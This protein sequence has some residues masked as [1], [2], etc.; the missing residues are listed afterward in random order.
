MDIQDIVREI[1]RATEVEQRQMKI[2]IMQA[3][4]EVERLK[5]DFL[6][7]D[8]DMKKMILFGSLPEDVI[9]S[10]DF[11]IDI[12]VQSKKYYQLV[13]RALQSD[14]KVDVVDLD[15][16]HE[17]IKKAIIENGRVIYEKKQG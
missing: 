13:S 11:D 7:I 9:G 8:K 16:I 10:I 2:R 17:R 1:K 5:I 15:S 6:K 12:A 4:E 3:Y 14:F